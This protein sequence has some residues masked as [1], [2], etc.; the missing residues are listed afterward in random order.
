MAFQVSD[1]AVDMMRALSRQIP[2][3]ANEMSQAGREIM[4]C[5]EQVKNTIGPHTKK[6]ETIVR[7]VDRLLKKNA[8]SILNVSSELEK[9]ANRC[10]YILDKKNFR[11]S[12]RVGYA[13]SVT[14]KIDDK[15]PQEMPVKGQRILQKGN[16]TEYER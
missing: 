2:D 9:L 8:D 12:Y 11:D 14:G 10:Q 6:I 13:P 5:Y 15:K 4:E 7:E 3:A 1:E 16:E